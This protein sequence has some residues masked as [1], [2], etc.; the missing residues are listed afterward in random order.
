MER[1]TRRFLYVY[2]SLVIM[3][4]ALGAYNQKQL[5][6][7]WSLMRTK[8]QHQVLLSDLRAQEAYIT[9]PLAVRQWAIDRGMVSTPEG[10]A[11]MTVY[12]VPAPS[13]DLPQAGGLEIRTVWR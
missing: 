5:M 7:H 1:R 3:L 11:A 12:P 2:L 13:Y 8:E 9:G 10:Q 4:T 6:T